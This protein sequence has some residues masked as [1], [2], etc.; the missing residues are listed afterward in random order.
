MTIEEIKNAKLSETTAGYLAIYLKL[1]RLLG[2]VSY[3]TSANYSD[4]TVDNVNKDVC[5][6][7]CHAMTEVMKLVNMSI[8]EN[9]G[10]LDNH[11]E[12]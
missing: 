9:L 12:I 2:D 11:T 4:A 5:D 8:T 3:V 1:D 7:I 10:F 6:A